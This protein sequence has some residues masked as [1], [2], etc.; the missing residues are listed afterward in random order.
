MWLRRRGGKEGGFTLAEILVAGLILVVALIPIVRMF[1]TSF[2]GIRSL[3]GVHK[4]VALGQK[5]MEEI[6]SMPYYV[7]CDEEQGKVDID[8][9]FWGDRS[10]VN[11]NPA[12]GDEPD[13]ES[14]P[15]VTI[16]KYAYGNIDK[17]HEYRVGVKLSYMGENMKP[18]EM[19][20]DWGPMKVAYDH[21]RDKDNRSIQLLLVQV[22]VYTM[23]GQDEVEEHRVEAIVT[24]TEAVYGLGITRIIV[25]G[26]D[27]I[28][29]SRSDAAAHDPNKTIDVTIEGWGFMPTNDPN[30]K[31]EV[32]LERPDFNPVEIT[33]PNINACTDTVIKGK[34]T[35]G[36]SKNN[37]D[38]K[39]KWKPR[40]PIGYWSVK[41]R[42]DI[43]STYL[44]NGFICEYPAPRI[45]DYGNDANHPNLPFKLPAMS[46]VG[47]K[48]W[49]TLHLKVQ[50]GYFINISGVASGPT[51]RLVEDVEGSPHAVTGVI[52]SLNTTD[53]GYSSSGCEMLVEFDITGEDVP[54][55]DYRLE[56]I[57]TQPEVVGHVSS[58]LSEQAYRIEEAPAWQAT[59]DDFS[60]DS[61]YGFYENYYDVPSTIT[62]TNLSEVSMVVIRSGDGVLYDITDDCTLGEDGQIPVN[63]N[64]IGCDHEKGWEMR[65]YHSSGAYAARDFDVTLGRAVMLEK[66]DPKKPVRIERYEK[67]ILGNWVYNS[68]S[69]ETG[70]EPANL[71]YARKSAIFTERA[72]IFEV[73]GMGFPMNGTTYLEMYGGGKVWAGNYNV[74]TDRESKLVWIRSD[75]FIM[76][77]TTWDDGGIKVRNGVGQEHNVVSRWRLMDTW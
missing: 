63:L 64:L 16:P 21:P 6:K 55:G 35:L 57:N 68:V 61:G 28:L 10:P 29:G 8:D 15:E 23:K 53:N 7:P 5:V 75:R 47:Y 51:V 11:Y 12:S 42:Q 56:V 71:A 30:K 44:Y 58:G 45:S 26:P 67:N 37:N 3:S 17:H 48:G 31:F 19:K 70:T 2:A 62:G 24:A 43:T 73:K 1:D 9:H 59:I 32:Q 34:V 38:A 25:D 41:V 72:A 39:N 33:I 65:A 54:P 22:N 46:K 66:G 77:N 49:G 50:G 20:E 4:S 40:E 13:W 76:P 36:T 18:V 69:E 14:I 60:P 52:T 74:Q 27:E